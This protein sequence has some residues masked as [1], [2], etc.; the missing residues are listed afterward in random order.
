MFYFCI[1][2]E[3]LMYVKFTTYIWD[4]CIFNLPQ[5]EWSVRNIVSKKAQKAVSVLSYPSMLYAPQYG[6]HA[7]FTRFECLMNVKEQWES[8]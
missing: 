6:P 2:A 7:H 4:E 3:S 5:N 1:Y 8:F